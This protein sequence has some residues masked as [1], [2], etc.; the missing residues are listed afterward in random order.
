MLDS[1]ADNAEGI[2]LTA[3]LEVIPTML[4]V[5][6][7]TNVL[8]SHADSAEGIVLTAVLD[9]LSADNAERIVLTAVL[10]SH[11]DDAEGW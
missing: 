1:H 6:L 8:D 7:L 3:V 11:A 10:D 2:V 5:I 4:K 9:R